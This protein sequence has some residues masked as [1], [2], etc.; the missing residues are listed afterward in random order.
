M[1]SAKLHN[2]RTG[3]K[4]RD[5]LWK[6][7]AKPLQEKAGST[8]THS[9]PDQPGCRTGRICKEKEILIFAHHHHVI[10]RG[11]RPDD[12]VVRRIQSK[13]PDV[14]SDMALVFEE[15]GEGRRQLVVNYEFHAPESTTWSA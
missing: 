1:A 13:L 6:T 4:R 9:N 14:T 10:R 11:V 5:D 12:I 3:F 15:S 2:M 7:N 8:I